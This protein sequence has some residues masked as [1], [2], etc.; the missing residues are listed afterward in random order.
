MR[1]RDAQISD[2]LLG[3]GDDVAEVYVNNNHLNVEIVFKASGTHM[4][5]A[6]TFAGP[7]RLTPFRRRFLFTAI[8]SYLLE[9]HP[10]VALA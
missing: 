10:H 5:V 2:P 7:M 3:V 6:N 4:K 9:T 8:S 1:P